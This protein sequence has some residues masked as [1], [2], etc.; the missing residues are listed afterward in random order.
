V[1]VVADGKT[2][3]DGRVTKSVATLMKWAARD[4]DRTLLFAA[5]VAVKPAQS[6]SAEGSGETRRSALGAP[7]R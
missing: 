3:F 4:N 1:K 5:E 6:A 2:V 7:R